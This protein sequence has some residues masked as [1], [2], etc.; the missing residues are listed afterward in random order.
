MPIHWILHT[1]VARYRHCRQ[2]DCFPRFYAR[3]GPTTPALGLSLLPNLSYLLWLS[4][5]VATDAVHH[6]VYRSNR[7]PIRH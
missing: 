1:D 6:N 4:L 2:H 3:L 7:G 5:R